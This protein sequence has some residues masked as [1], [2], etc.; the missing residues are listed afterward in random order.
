[1]PQTQAEPLIDTSVLDEMI[2]WIKALTGVGVS[3]DMAANVTSKFFIAAC[4]MTADEE[5]YED[6]YAEE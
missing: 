2:Q 1:M 3:A 6:E 4:D 5:E